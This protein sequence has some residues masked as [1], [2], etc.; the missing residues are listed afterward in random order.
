M[1]SDFEIIEAKEK[2]RE[3]FG[4]CYGYDIFKIT[5]EDIEALLNGKELATTI[6][7]D[8][9]SIFIELIDNEK[10]EE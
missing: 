1:K 10:V 7:A 2:A 4:Y 8:E 3:K 6:N 5:K 9:Y